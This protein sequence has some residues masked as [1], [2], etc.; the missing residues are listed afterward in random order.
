[1]DD[2]RKEILGIE[3]TSRMSYN[4]EQVAIYHAVGLSAKPIRC[5][6]SNTKM[7]ADRE[8]DLLTMRLYTALIMVDKRN[9]IPSKIS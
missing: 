4:R 8:I 3:G 2:S 9:C 7:S 5:D 1:M 6:V